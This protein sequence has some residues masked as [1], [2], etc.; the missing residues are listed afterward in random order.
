MDYRP[1]LID[2]R[3]ERALRVFPSVS[4]VGPRAS[5]KTTSAARLATSV[6]RLDVPAT[7][8]VFASDVDAALAVRARPALLDEWQHVPSILGAVKRAVDADSAPGQ[9]ILTGSVT[10]ELDHDTWAGTGRVIR[11]SMGTM[12]R[13]ETL[14][15]IDALPA[16]RAM[17]SG[18]VQ[19][20]TE[21]PDIVGYVDLALR[22]GFPEATVLDDWR[23]RRLW[24]D[25][26][27]DQLVN[28]DAVADGRD[29]AR[30]RQYLQSWALNSAGIVDDVTLYGAAGI[31]RRTHLAYEQLLVN[32]FVAQIVP[33]WTSN[34]F[35]RLVLA[36]KRYICDS[37]LMAGSARIGRDD[38]LSND[39]LLGRI[40][41]TFVFNELSARVGAD[42][43]RATLHH[44][45]TAG[46]RQE[47]DLIVE[48]D[49]GHLYGVEVKATS[50]PT[51]RHARHLIWMR[52]EL[53]ASF[54]GG[55]VLHTGP[56]I[57]E[58][59]DRIIALPICALWGTRV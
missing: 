12:T 29:A 14:G 33:A 8:A 50:V 42:D 16:L 56:E 1:R 59:A 43:D 22:G 58:L 31:D 23:D 21:V 49:G 34:R 40:V 45:R 19:M 4:L 28:R 5:G 17:L 30:L 7:A 24:M 6:T 18:Q 38:V 13:A 51:P 20:P 44:L 41:D 10:A 32:L 55:V 39:D 36:P 54:A 48:F 9:F 26:Y 15:S 57:I 35:K 25:S 11:L 46:G 3:L 47:V 27:V 37:A 52:D 2:Q 53:G